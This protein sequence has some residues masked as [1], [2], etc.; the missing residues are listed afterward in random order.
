MSRRMY[1]TN[2]EAHNRNTDRSRGIRILLRLRDGLAGGIKRSCPGR[3]ISTLTAVVVIALTFLPINLQAIERFP[4]P[5][6]ESGYT[7]LTPT[8]PLPRGMYFD[9]QDCVVLVLA[10]AVTTYFALKRRSRKGI[11]AV[12]IFSL[13]YFG[14][15][16]RGCVCAVGSVQNVACALGDHSYVIPFSVILFFL[17]PLITALLFGR[18]FCAG[19]CPLGAVQ[20]IVIIRP[21]KLP[22]WINRALGMIPYVYLG[23]AILFAVTASSFIICRYD[24]FISLFRLSGPL[25]V[26][27]LGVCFLALGT[28]IARP[29]CRFLCPYGVLLNWMSRLS[30]RHVAI[31]PEECIQCR[32]CADSCP[33]DAIRMPTARPG[34]AQMKTAR[35]RLIAL[36]ILLPL[37]TIGGGWL[38]SRLAPTLAL[39][40]PTVQLAEQ[41]AREDAGR[42]E[43][44]TLD[45]SAFRSSGTPTANL[46]ADAEK[47][48]KQFFVGS[49]ILGIFSGTVFGLTLIGLSVF[50]A[51][52]DFEPDRGT[53][54]SCGRCFSYCPV[55]PG[56]T[57]KPE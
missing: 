45:S 15:W 3:T 34:A 11:F 29:Y 23:L 20:D 10:L 46:Y 14:F 7:Y 33:F 51:R 19:V 28:V 17:L 4:K 30:L 55:K 6:F 39:V 9:Y 8:R 1:T 32:L 52:K 22:G 53:C 57:L 54:L 21:L 31:T 40:N 26:I 47:I 5:E 56:M 48:R 38:V 12:M 13:A 25:A 43:G 36:I 18:M 37:L 44:P 42:V 35:V 2:D 24:P 16:R 50:R 49:W 27:L 41:I